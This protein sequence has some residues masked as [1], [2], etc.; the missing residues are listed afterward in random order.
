M[1]HRP[2]NDS[3]NTHDRAWFG[4]LAFGLCHFLA[5]ISPTGVYYLGGGDS[6]EGALW[7]CANIKSKIQNPNVK[8]ILIY[9]FQNPN[10]K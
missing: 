7:K 1:A 10:V 3:R 4:I 8:Q 2:D 5:S 6:G 9:K